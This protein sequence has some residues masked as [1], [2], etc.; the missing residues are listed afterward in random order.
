[1]A[2][3]TSAPANKAL[4][5]QGRPRREPS[6]AAK[7]SVTRKRAKSAINRGLVSEKAAKRH[8]GD[9]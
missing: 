5:Y 7:K 1:M 9:V 2:D 8:L 3:T 4:A 6:G